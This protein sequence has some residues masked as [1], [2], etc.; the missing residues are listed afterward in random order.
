M[1]LFFHTCDSAIG[2]LHDNVYQYYNKYFDL[3]IL[4]DINFGD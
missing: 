4:I 2:V 3:K 1:W